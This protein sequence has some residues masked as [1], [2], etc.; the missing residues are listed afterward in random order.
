VSSLMSSGKELVGASGEAE[1]VVSVIILG[2]AFSLRLCIIRKGVWTFPK[3]V[4]TV[5]VR[6]QH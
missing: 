3:K 4:M 1:G 5:F 2:E 6:M